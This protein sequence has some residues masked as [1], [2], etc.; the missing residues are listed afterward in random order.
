[1]WSFTSTAIHF[2]VH[3]LLQFAHY[4]DLLFSTPVETDAVV[5][6]SWARCMRELVVCSVLEFKV[7]TSFVK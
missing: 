7:K 1:M 4:R 3:S 2:E 6:H 5:E